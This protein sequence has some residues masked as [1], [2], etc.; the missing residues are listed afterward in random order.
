MHKAKTGRN[1][2]NN[3]LIYNIARDFKIHSKKIDRTLTPDWADWPLHKMSPNEN[4]LHILLNYTKN[5]N[6]GRTSSMS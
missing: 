1:E 6:Q 3:R 2:R 5:V 4:R